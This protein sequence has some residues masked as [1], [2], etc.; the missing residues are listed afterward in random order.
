M[1]QIIVPISGGN[2]PPV[3]PTSFV[4]DSGTVIPAANVVNID[5]GTTTTNSANGI[6]VVANPNGSNNMVI[7]LTNRQNGAVTTTDATPTTLISFATA[8]SAAVY[9]VQV[10][11]AAFDATDVAGA[12]YHI[13]AGARTTGAAVTIFPDPDFVDNEEAAMVT[14][15]INILASGNNIIIQVTGIA[16][17]T[18]RWSGSL[19]FVQVV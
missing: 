6:L 15:D 3:V 7:E 14:S 18:I 19:T 4:T 10:R 13:D 1:S 12:A 17:K 5:G 16:G 11:I 8:A 9:N 2:L